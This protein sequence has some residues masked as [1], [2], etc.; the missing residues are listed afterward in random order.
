MKIAWDLHE[1]STI[2][3]YR[4]LEHYMKREN[5]FDKE[6]IRSTCR[7]HEV[8]V[9]RAWDLNEESMRCT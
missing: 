1:K 7:K 3:P 9:K 5:E 4:G 6:S 8:Y 2:S